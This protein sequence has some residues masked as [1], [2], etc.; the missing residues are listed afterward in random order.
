[1]ILSWFDA[2][3]AKAFGLE[4]ADFYIARVKKN[5]DGLREKFVEKK[6][7]EL[8][9]KIAQKIVAFKSTHSLNIYKKAQVGNVK[10]SGWPSALM[11]GYNGKASSPRP[12]FT[13]LWK[14]RRSI[15]F[16]GVASLGSA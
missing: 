8:L 2:K 14:A 16:D 1:M 15:S 13:K 10:S 7:R 12:S 5:S 6:Q 3:E 4:M 9:A 11:R